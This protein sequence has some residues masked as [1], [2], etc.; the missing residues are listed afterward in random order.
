M[1]VTGVR[2]ISAV[3]AGEE[4]FWQS[5]CTVTKR[6]FY[7]QKC[8]E[9]GNFSDY[10]VYVAGPLVGAAAAVGIAF[11]LRGAGGGRSGSGAAQ[12]ALFTEA[13]EEEKP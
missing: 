3:T 1:Y 6:G 11:I 8:F 7:R 5:I 9:R 4:Y 12:G 2:R 13:A 10:W